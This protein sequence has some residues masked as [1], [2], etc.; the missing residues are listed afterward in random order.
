MTKDVNEIAVALRDTL[1]SEAVVDGDGGVANVVDA[2]N[3]IAEAL[4][5]G[6]RRY[7]K[8][9]EEATMHLAQAIHNHG[10]T[11]YDGLLAIAQQL[12]R[13]AQNLSDADIARQEAE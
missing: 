6:A 11:L 1:V 5:F 3:H 2:V 13:I 8:H 12:E 7:E 4:L 9:D 10:T